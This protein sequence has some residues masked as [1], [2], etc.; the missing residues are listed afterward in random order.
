MGEAIGTHITPRH[1][2]LKILLLIGDDPANSSGRFG[3]ISFTPGDE[4]DVSVHN[5]LPCDLTD[6]KANV[7]TDDGGI[8]FKETAAKAKKQHFRV[9]ALKRCHRKEIPGVPE[10][11]NQMMPR[12]HRIFILQSKD[13]TP[14]LDNLLSGVAAAKRAI[15]NIHSDPFPEPSDPWGKFLNYHLGWPFSYPNSGR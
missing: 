1:G 14:D 10:R 9:P 8:F 4:M 2:D 11:H 13:R 7:E 3:I 5:G 15:D 12:G 6:I